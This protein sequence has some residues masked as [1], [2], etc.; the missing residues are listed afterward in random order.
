M[1]RVGGRVV[2]RIGPAWRGGFLMSRSDPRLHP[3]VD[4]DAAGKYVTLFPSRLSTLR[5]TAVVI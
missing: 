2:V 5:S 1:G 3:L 4:F